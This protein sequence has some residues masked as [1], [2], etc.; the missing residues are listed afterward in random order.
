MDLASYLV[1]TGITAAS[2]IEGMR[3]GT[4]YFQLERLYRNGEI[5]EKPNLWNCRRL[6]RKYQTLME[7]E[8]EQTMVGIEL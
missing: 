1:L 7:K 8:F 2:A 4:F 6:R 5:T 3:R